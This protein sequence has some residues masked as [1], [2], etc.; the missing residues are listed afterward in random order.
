LNKMS[1]EDVSEGYRTVLEIV[2]KTVKQTQTL[3]REIQTSEIPAIRKTVSKSPNLEF[4]RKSLEI[5]LVDDSK[6]LE[7]ASEELETPAEPAELVNDSYAMARQR[8]LEEGV[9][10]S[11]LEVWKHE[12]N[13][14][15]KRGDI[16]YNR[17]GMQGLA[18]DWV[19]AM[20]PNLEKHIEN[21][22]PKNVNSDG[23]EVVPSIE[24]DT[25]SARL[26]HLWLTALPIDTLCAITVVELLRAMTNEFRSMGSRA[27]NLIQGI[28]RSVEKEMQASD[29]V[30]KE[31][32]GMHPKHLNVRHLLLNKRAAEN[33]ARKFRKE[34]LLSKSGVTH[35][36]FEWRN[37][38]RA[39]VTHLILTTNS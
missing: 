15:M 27:T 24:K 12:M 11:A 14:A 39:R 19:Q 35:W 31:N 25:T 38:I 2:I 33:Y 26:E 5:L 22:R 6:A 18:W 21:I 9:Y 7:K 29:V 23:L 17:L 8:Q 3:L 16:Y 30:R 36:P 20:K 32:R 34:L 4:M 13:E 10:A 1:L 37:D 28:G